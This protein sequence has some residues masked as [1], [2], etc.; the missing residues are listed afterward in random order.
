MRFS[1]I[2]ARKTEMAVETACLVLEVSPSGYY[3]WKSRPA[4][5]RQRHDMVVLAHIREQFEISRETYGS[6]RM[7]VELQQE[8]IEAGRHR[9][10]RLMRDNGLKARQKTRFRKTTD[11]AHAG[12]IASNMLDQD[13]AADQPNQK[14]GVDISY[15]WTAEGWLYLAIVLDMFSRRIVGWAVHD[16]MKKGLAME[17][18]QRAIALRRPAKGLIHHSDRGSQY[19]ADDYRKLINDNQ[20]TA[21]MSGKGNC[22]DNAIVE[23]VFKTIKAELIWRTSFQSRLEAQSAIGEYIEGFYNPKRRHSALGYKSPI[24]FEKSL[25]VKQG[26]EQNALH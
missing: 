8:G 5:K 3:A 2:D 19:C 4:S 11:S 18:L 15:I 25:Q 7:H 20:F 12:P 23:T 22:F 17:A 21:S 24:D 14:W 9:V 10:A 13:F 1:L 26:K 16:R 6:P